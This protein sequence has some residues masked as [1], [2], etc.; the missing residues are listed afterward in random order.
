MNNK[1]NS[2]YKYYHIIS[3]IS[4]WWIWVVDFSSNYKSFKTKTEIKEVQG[5]IE[6]DQSL[7]NVMITNI[8]SFLNK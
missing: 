2:D 6:K 8:L 1:D 3:Y 4:K 5:L 7:Q